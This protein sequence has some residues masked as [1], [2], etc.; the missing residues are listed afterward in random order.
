M[1]GF[2]HLPKTGGT[3]VR[4]AFEESGAAVW[5]P[6][7]PRYQ[8]HL[9]GKIQG[10]DVA[11]GH[12]T[13]ASLESMGPSE[14]FTVV[15]EPVAR[16]M[17]HYFMESGLI[18]RGYWPDPDVVPDNIMTRLLGAAESPL[19]DEPDLDAALANLERLDHVG[20]TDRLNETFLRYGL[21][22]TRERVGS[23]DKAEAPTW[24]VDAA[25]ERTRLDAAVYKR[26]LELT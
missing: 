25:Y 13:F 7:G 16:F 21:E 9:R 24:L 6:R 2:L 26:A 11:T 15:R 3:S 5:R 4:T 22:P 19:T 10:F 17:S 1:I 12:L 20:F 8:G 23:R 18:E 14:M